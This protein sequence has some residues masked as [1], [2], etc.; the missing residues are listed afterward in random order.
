MTRSGS[1]FASP[2]IFLLKKKRNAGSL[3]FVFNQPAGKLPNSSLFVFNYWSLQ[4]L[5]SFGLYIQ[6]ITV[7]ISM[8]CQQ[9]RGAVFELAK[10][11]E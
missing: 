2:N 4:E 8:M 9:N 7:V 5:R 3:T 10:T 1:S 6:Y 11:G